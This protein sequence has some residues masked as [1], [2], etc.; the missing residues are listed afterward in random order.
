MKYILR[1]LW[2]IG[3][4]PVYILAYACLFVMMFIYPLICVFYFIKT[5]DC[6]KIPFYFY[7]LSVYIDNKYRELLKYL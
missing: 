3:C 7:S 2:L 6:E 5:G 4:V 1:T